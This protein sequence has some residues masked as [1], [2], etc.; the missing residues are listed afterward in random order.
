MK[1]GLA[2]FVACT[3]ILT[4]AQGAF[5]FAHH[6]I[7]KDLPGDSY[8]Q[9]ALV[10]LDQ[11]GDLDFITGGKDRNK[12]IYWFEYAGPDNWIRHVLGTNHPSEVGGVAIDVDRDGWI[13]QVT[14]GA[15]YRNTGKP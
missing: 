10:D 11:D 3:L 1:S 5:K 4:S 9:T 14:G 15:W 8:G 7:D 6:Y 12:S 13:D 2:F